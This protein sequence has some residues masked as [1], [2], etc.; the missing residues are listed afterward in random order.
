[1][2]IINPSACSQGAGMCIYFGSVRVL[3]SRI[4]NNHA[5]VE[6]GGGLQVISSGEIAVED[7]EI[8]ENTACS[9]SKHAHYNEITVLIAR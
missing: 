2:P 1:M 5:T 4:Y 9:V 3:G 7:S 8:S 6:H